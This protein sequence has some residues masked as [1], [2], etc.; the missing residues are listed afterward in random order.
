MKCETLIYALV[1]ICFS[2][3]DKEECHQSISFNNLSSDTIFLASKGTSD[4]KCLLGGRILRPGEFENFEL[5]RRNCYELRIT[6]KNKFV[7]Y[8]LNPTKVN[9]PTVHYDCDSIP[10]KNDILK[11]YELSVQDLRNLNWKITYP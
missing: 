1:L 11:M 10:I 3:I 7:L 5:L 9:P 6:D 8:V 2:C 4:G